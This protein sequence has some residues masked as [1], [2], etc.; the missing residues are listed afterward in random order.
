MTWKPT[1]A[2]ALVAG[3]LLG[4]AADRPTSPPLDTTQDPAA[5]LT[6][7]SARAG[8]YLGHTRLMRRFDAQ[9][10]ALYAQHIPEWL[11]YW[12]ADATYDYVPAGVPMT[13]QAAIQTFFEDLFTGFPD[14]RPV[15][16]LRLSRGNLVVTEHFTAAHHDGPW[17]GRQ[18]E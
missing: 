9:S 5:R 16:E 2:I 7:A 8:G 6:V 4:C 11:T 18:G 17:Q 15:D 1:A 10:A 14:F 13:T 12:A 3:L